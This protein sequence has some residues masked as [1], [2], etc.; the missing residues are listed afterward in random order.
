MSDQKQ[1][2]INWI[3]L[4]RR[5]SHSLNVDRTTAGG[6]VIDWVL[7]GAENDPDFDRNAIPVDEVEELIAM[8][9]SIHNSRQAEEDKATNQ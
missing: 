8:F 4:G 5:V 3:E 7:M 9:A 6:Y 2:T 1:H